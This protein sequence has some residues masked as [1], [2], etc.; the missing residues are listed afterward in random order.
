MLKLSVV[1]LVVV[2]FWREPFLESL[3]TV[4]S[5]SKTIF[6]VSFEQIAEQKLRFLPQKVRH[7]QFRF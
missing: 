2:I 4:R 6:W 3:R 1:L 5:R 7:G